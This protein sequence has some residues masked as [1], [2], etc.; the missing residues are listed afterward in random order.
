MRPASTPLPRQSYVQ[1]LAQATQEDLDREDLFDFR[2]KLEMNVVAE[3]WINGWKIV[4]I[5]PDL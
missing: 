5:T 4:D 2:I 3:V 1:W